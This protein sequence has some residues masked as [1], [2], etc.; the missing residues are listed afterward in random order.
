M[1]SLGHYYIQFH[2]PYTTRHAVDKDPS[3]LTYLH[4]SSESLSFPASASSRSDHNIDMTGGE[5]E[6]D[7][8]GV[9]YSSWRR[10]S[11]LLPTPFSFVSSPFFEHIQFIFN[12]KHVS[13]RQIFR[14]RTA[15]YVCITYPKYSKVSLSNARQLHIILITLSFKCTNYCFLIFVYATTRLNKVMVS[16]AKF[17]ITLSEAPVRHSGE[18]RNP[19]KEIVSIQTGIAEVR[20][21]NTS[22]FFHLIIKRNWLQIYSSKFL[23]S[24]SCPNLINNNIA[25]KYRWVLLPALHPEILE[26]FLKSSSHTGSGSPFRSVIIL[27]MADASLEWTV[28]DTSCAIL[29]HGVAVPSWRHSWRRQRV[30]VNSS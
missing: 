22:E 7:W 28:S 17:F 18:R 23:H 19:R 8:F 29:L 2:P 20:V 11:F 9:E 1:L 21:S 4:T 25:V 12:P 27:A 24:L 15:A 5:D 3:V 26:H 16:D 30:T 14:I 10:F 6:D 13:I